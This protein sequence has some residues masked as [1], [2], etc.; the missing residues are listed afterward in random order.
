MSEDEGV[1][2]GDREGVRMEGEIKARERL[3]S[4]KEEGEG[5]KVY[6]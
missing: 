4:W 1:L 3:S 6:I 5:K 2:S